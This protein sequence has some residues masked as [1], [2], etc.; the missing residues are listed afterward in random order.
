MS[1][2]L[3][4]TAPTTERPVLTLARLL[5]NQPDLDE[6]A[7]L[8]TALTCWPVGAE[9]CFFVRANGSGFDLLAGYTDPLRSALEPDGRLI[10]SID[11]I[12]HATDDGPAIWSE[13]TDSDV[14][15]MAAWPLNGSHDLRLVLVL[16]D[17]IDASIVTARLSELLDI[18][19][20]YV[21][22]MLAANDPRNNG[23]RIRHVTSAPSL[24]PRQLQTLQLIERN[25][26][27]RQIAAR[28]GFSESTVRM[29]SLAIYRALGVHDRRGAV[30]VGRK[31]GLL[32]PE[33][34]APSFE[35]N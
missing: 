32:G 16:N 28:I 2:T 21:A 29:E 8:L 25:F 30:S 26:T 18:V 35:H 22:G 13:P 4:L 33:R 7:R 5:A 23:R 6:T 14:V 10:P 15:P 20:V 9:S 11:A 17:H 31:L 27:M 3:E 12:A 1:A 34:E 19:A 24:S